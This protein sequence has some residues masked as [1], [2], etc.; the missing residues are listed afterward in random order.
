MNVAR[1]PLY[2][3]GFL[4]PFG[5]LVM[6]PMLPELRDAFDASNSAVGLG[7]TVYLVV[8]AAFLL[9]AGSVGARVGRQ[10]TLRI[11]YFVYAVAAIVVVLS[12]SLSVFL[13]ARSVQGA[14]NAF[15]TPLLIAALADLVPAERFG[16]VVGTYGSFQAI[17]GAGAPLVGG[18][19]ADVDWRWAF[20]VVAVLSVVLA[21]TVPADRGALAAPDWRAVASP[22]PVWLS[23]AMVIAAAGPLGVAV[24]VGVM[25]R[26]VIGLTGTSAGLVLLIG[27]AAPIVLAPA[28]GLVVDRLGPGASARLALVAST[29]ATA[30]LAA[31]T[32][33]I[34]LGVAWLIAS[35]G[36]ATTIV[37]VQAF[38]ATIDPE[39]RSGVISFVLSGRFTGL[40]IAPVA[41]LPVFESNPTAAFLGAAALGPLALLV[42][43]RSI[44]LVDGAAGERAT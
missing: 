17:G 36:V 11:A 35:V 2:A 44:R 29:L 14:A 13:I 19:T 31:G 4:G 43:H 9:F 25:A 15:F 12:P 6:V 33:S 26:D 20:V 10:R 18:I 40:A 34:R 38:A 24:L 5:T 3:G 21:L 16:R 32:T 7:L 23:T 1:L 30:G 22:A 41:W 37:S 42:M 28:W 39:Q 8:F 27:G